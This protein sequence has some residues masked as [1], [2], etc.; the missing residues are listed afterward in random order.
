MYLEYRPVLL[1]LLEAPGLD[2]PSVD[3]GAIAGGEPELLRLFT[4]SVLSN[5][6]CKYVRRL[7]PFSS[8]IQSSKGVTRSE[9]V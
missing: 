1:A 3:F 9:E 8:L 5:S 6:L 4:L 7:V 2:D